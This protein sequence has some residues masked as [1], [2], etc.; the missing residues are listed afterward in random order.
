MSGDLLPPQLLYQ[1]KTEHC[2]HKVDFPEEWDIW[3][4][5]NH[6][7]NESTMIQ[8]ADEILIPY[9]REMHNKLDLPLKQPALAVFDVFAAHH[10]YVLTNIIISEESE[11]MCS[12]QVLYLCMYIVV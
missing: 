2:H 7:S 1:G 9:V 12:K 5:E 4:S 8:F 10:G 11:E 6:W 3:Y